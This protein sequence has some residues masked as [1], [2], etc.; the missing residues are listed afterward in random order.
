MLVHCCVLLLSLLL[1]YLLI[2]PPPAFP[3]PL[4]PPRP[5]QIM[6]S[7]ETSAA[8]IGLVSQLQKSISLVALKHEAHLSALSMCAQGCVLNATPQIL[9]LLPCVQGSHPNLYVAPAPPW[10]LPAPL[11]RPLPFHCQRPNI[12]AV[13]LTSHEAA[14]SNASAWYTSH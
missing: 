6:L 10:P 4:P 3:P 14:S 1:A 7:Q 13:K 5:P 2:F 12:L 11:P 8:G 9:S